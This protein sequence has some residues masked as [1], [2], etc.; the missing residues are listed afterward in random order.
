MA[1]GEQRQQSP[2]D[3]SIV[4]GRTP[5]RLRHRNTLTVRPATVAAQNKE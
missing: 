3:A 5:S 2:G 1:G 4:A